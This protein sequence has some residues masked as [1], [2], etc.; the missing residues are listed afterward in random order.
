M[1]KE[2]SFVGFNPAAGDIGEKE[3]E[4]M[5]FSFKTNEDMA[6]FIKLREQQGLNQNSVTYNGRI[7]PIELDIGYIC[8]GVACE[9]DKD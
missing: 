7:I 9:S 8:E 2:L 4:R 6:A 3:C 1:G 5:S